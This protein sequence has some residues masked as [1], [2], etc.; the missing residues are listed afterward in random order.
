MHNF[1]NRDK[2]NRVAIG[3]VIAQTLGVARNA[4]CAVIG[5]VA[6]FS[7]RTKLVCWLL[8]FLC[9]YRLGL[10]VLYSASLAALPW[11]LITGKSS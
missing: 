3:S 1:F 5:S 4:G 8:M 7:A 2:G 9:A 10:P 11:L 6:G